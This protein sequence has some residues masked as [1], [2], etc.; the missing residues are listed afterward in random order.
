MPN[1][2]TYSSAI[3][4][5]G[6]GGEWQVVMQLL[7]EMPYKWLMPETAARIVGSQSSASYVTNEEGAGPRGESAAVNDRV[8]EA[9][10][11]LT[12]MS[13]SVSR[14]SVSRISS[15]PRLV[16]ALKKLIAERSR[17]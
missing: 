9:G 12:S 5:S 6:D 4:A 7:H 2:V 15:L 10:G 17:G 3:K 11:S 13:R 8:S 16:A 1:V 14:I